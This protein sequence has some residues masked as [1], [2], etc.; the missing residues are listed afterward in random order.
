TSLWEVSMVGIRTR[1]FAAH[2]TAGLVAG[3]ALLMLLGFSS[4]ARAQVFGNWQ[5]PSQLTSGTTIA[6][7]T[8]QPIDVN[9]ADGQVFTGVVDQDVFDTTGRLA[10][11]RGSTAELVVRTA[12]NNE[13]ALD[14]DSVMVNG[15]RYAIAANQNIVGTTGSF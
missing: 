15:Q 1:Y 7:R 11:P 4:N 14:L 9:R 2:G 10:I 8:S 5:A 12:P 13:L 3:I 6:V